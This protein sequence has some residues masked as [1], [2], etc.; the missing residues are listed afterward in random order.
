V[1]KY[2][3]NE[4]FDTF[5]E[6]TLGCNETNCQSNTNTNTFDIED[7]DL[8]TELNE[9]DDEE[10]ARCIQNSIVEE[11]DEPPPSYESIYKQNTLNILDFDDCFQDYP[12][13]SSCY[14]PINNRP[15]L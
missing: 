11:N 2:I 15:D 13:S 8:N 3:P 6:Q 9:W 14:I 7:F 4:M 10:I 1:Q 12:L 5:H